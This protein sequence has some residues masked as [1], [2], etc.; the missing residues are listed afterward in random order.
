M[1][2][3]FVGG[4]ADG[5]G[6]AV[7]QH[8]AN[9]T[10]FPH[11]FLLTGNVYH[12]WFL[13]SLLQGI[14]LVWLCLRFWKLRGAVL[15]GGAFYAA[16]LLG[17]YAGTRIGFSTNFDMKIGPFTSALFVALGACLAQR[18]K[19]SIAPGL[20]LVAIGLVGHLSEGYWLRH[21]FSRPLIQ[22]D[23]LIG[24]IPYSVGL[25]WLALARPTSG[26]GLAGIGA[27]SLGIYVLHVYVIECLRLLPLK[28]MIVY[29]PWIFVGIV[30]AVTWAVVYVL[31]KVRGL[32]AFLR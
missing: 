9:I 23:Y 32:R 22:N 27:A 6:V 18:Q 28:G 20:A 10:R 29:L 13:S 31:G 2:P 30:L 17:G 12:L 21:A 25:V 7:R 26:Q 14:C 3:P 11:Y 15:V 19:F 16:V 1:V 24:T 8:L 4:A 5:Y